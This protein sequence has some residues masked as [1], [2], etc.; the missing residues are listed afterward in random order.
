M[1]GGFG[2]EN[3]AGFDLDSEK[4]ESVVDNAIAAGFSAE[5]PENAVSLEDGAIEECGFGEIA[6]VFCGS[7]AGVAPILKLGPD[8]RMG[9]EEA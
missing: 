5:G 7:H 6:A 4:I 9:V 2:I 8:F 1:V 3:F